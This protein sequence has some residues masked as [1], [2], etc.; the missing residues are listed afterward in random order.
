MTKFLSTKPRRKRTRRNFLA[1]YLARNYSFA[2]LCRFDG[3]VP[4]RASYDCAKS[5]NKKSATW[6]D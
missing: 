5:Q 6:T 2:D 3:N 1:E 4:S